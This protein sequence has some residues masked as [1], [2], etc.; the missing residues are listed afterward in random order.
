M[1]GFHIHSQPTGANHNCTAG[2]AHFNPYN[3]SHGMPQDPVMQRHVGDI[4]DGGH[5]GKGESNTTGNAGPRIA[6]GTILFI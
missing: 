3:A 1:L 4:D 5:T 2:G 6:C